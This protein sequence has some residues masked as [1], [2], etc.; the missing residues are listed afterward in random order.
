[1]EKWLRKLAELLERNDKYDP[2]IDEVS[3][4]EVLETVKE[5]IAELYQAVEKSDIE[6]I[7]EELG[8]LL[9]TALLVV[10][11]VKRNFDIDVEEAIE[12][13]EKKMRNRKPYIFEGIKP[14]LNEAVDI[15]I[16][17]KEK[18]IKRPQC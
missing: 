15:W 8:D 13:L 5:E 3:V 7:K 18:E 9:W 17:A 12:L 11:S 1:M 10:L 14:T 6:N 16:K 2:W 4:Q